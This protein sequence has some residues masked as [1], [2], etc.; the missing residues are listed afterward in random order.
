MF[1]KKEEIRETD[2]GNKRETRDDFKCAPDAS[3]AASRKRVRFRPSQINLPPAFT[4]V[5]GSTMPVLEAV[6]KSS[7]ECKS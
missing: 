7:S 5:A 1:Y 6:L 3:E 4:R 2:G